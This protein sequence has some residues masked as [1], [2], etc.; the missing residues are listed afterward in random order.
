MLKEKLNQLLA[1]LNK[2]ILDEEAQISELS[3]S[4]AND[5]LDLRN[6]L[7]QIVNKI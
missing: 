6:K 3:G 7:Q 2:L 5:I 1:D 4:K